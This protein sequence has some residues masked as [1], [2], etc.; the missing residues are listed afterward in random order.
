[1]KEYEKTIRKSIRKNETPF[2]P[3][4]FLWS[5]HFSTSS[6]VSGFLIRMDPFATWH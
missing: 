2:A 3:N 4:T 1:M 6:F 5:T